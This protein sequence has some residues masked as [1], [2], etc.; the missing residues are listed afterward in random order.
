[1]REFEQHIE[2]FEVLYLLPRVL[3]ARRRTAIL[4][5]IAA[6]ALSVGFIAFFGY[7]AVCVYMQVEA[8]SLFCAPIALLLTIGN[9]LGL[10]SRENPVMSDSRLTYLQFIAPAYN[11]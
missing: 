1:M 4:A 7:L 6:A 9:T 10:I 5:A 3:E 2:E 8:D 11:K